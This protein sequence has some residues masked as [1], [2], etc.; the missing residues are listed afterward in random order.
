MVRT[1]FHSIKR[2]LMPSTPSFIIIIIIIIFMAVF[3]TFAWL[4]QRAHYGN[5]IVFRLSRL[6]TMKM[7]NL[8]LPR[9]EEESPR[10]LEDLF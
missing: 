6:K 4:E 9:R 3:V 10:M 2:H 8:N 1:S 7:I 5:V